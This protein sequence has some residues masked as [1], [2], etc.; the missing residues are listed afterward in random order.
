VTEHTVR[1]SIKPDAN[2]A[3]AI[4]LG[5][6]VIYC[7]GLHDEKFLKKYLDLLPEKYSLRSVGGKPNL[8]KILETPPPVPTIGLVDADFDHILG[9]N[10]NIVELHLSDHHDIE[11]DLI[12]SD[13]FRRSVRDE[14]NGYDLEKRIQ[15]IYEKCFNLSLLKYVSSKNNLRLCFNDLKFRDWYG[16]TIEELAQKLLSFKNNKA[17]HGNQDNINLVKTAQKYENQ[18]K[19]L[20][21]KQ[22]HNGKDLF[23]SIHYDLQEYIKKSKQ[24]PKP[25]LPP[26]EED[27]KKEA[28]IAFREADFQCMSFFKGLKDFSESHKL[29]IFNF[30][31]T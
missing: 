12:L 15:E 16:K 23:Y 13:A 22:F 29:N 26:T 4:L 19:E 30:Q 17:F 9:L 2:V 7:E 21:P 6:P 27:L 10:K 24:K 18:A 3:E 5:L 31:Y 14:Y 8:L 25:R 1:D 28:R 11:V 20:C